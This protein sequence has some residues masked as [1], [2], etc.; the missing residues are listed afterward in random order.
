MEGTVRKSPRIRST[1][2]QWAVIIA[3]AILLHVALLLFVQPRYFNIF[4]REIPAGEEGEDRY[5]FLDR[6]F[7]VLS[8]SLETAPAHSVTRKETAAESETA[9]DVASVEAIGEP[10]S[11]MLPLAGGGGGSGRPGSRNAI[12]EPKPLFIPWPKYPRGLKQIPRGTVELLLLV[13]ERGD[14]EEVKVSRALSLSELNSIAVE[15]ARKIR[16]TPGTEKGI[17]KAMWVRLA[18]GFQPR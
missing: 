7:H 10:Q 1:R 16:F 5:P 13:N 15:A 8:L 11:E 14:V 18:V 9:E 4:R 2:R 3:A 12:V 6:P 17:R